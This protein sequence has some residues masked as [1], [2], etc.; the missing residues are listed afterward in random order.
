MPSVPSGFILAGT[1]QKTVAPK[2]MTLDMKA[3]SKVK[4]SHS[5]SNGNLHLSGIITYKGFCI[6]DV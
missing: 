5:F 4:I 2:I 1:E 6:I 3:H